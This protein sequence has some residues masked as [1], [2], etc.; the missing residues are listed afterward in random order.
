MPLFITATYQVKEESIKKIKKAIENFTAYVKK[1]ESGTK[2]YMAW[3]DEKDPTKFTHI[4]IFQ[5]EKAR[6]D[7][8]NSKE[9]MKFEEVYTPELVG[10]PV[11]FAHFYEIATNK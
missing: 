5:D 7:H 4:F 10:G 11:Q 6:I 9:A 1:H 2:L 3:Q 8:S